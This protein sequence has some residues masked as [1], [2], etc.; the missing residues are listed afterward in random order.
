MRWERC[1]STFSHNAEDNILNSRH[2]DIQNVLPRLPVYE[3]Y[4]YLGWRKNIHVKPYHC[5]MRIIKICVTSCIGY[6]DINY[7]GQLKYNNQ[8]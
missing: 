3:M 5:I 7:C 8:G 6:T 2:P 4:K 1:T